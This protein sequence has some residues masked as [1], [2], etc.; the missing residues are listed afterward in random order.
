[1]T[2]KRRIW[3]QAGPGHSHWV[4]LD[5]R[6]YG[7][8]ASRQDAEALASE[9]RAAGRDATTGHIDIAKTMTPGSKAKTRDRQRKAQQGK[10][11]DGQ[12]TAVIIRCVPG[13]P[14]QLVPA[15]AERQLEAG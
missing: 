2:S 11:P 7:W 10:R 3:K 9:F 5:A 1:M 6:V 8:L 15:S 13:Q 4:R 14:C 12:P